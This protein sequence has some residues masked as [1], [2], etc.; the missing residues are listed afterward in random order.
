[1]KLLLDTH[2][3][4]WAAGQSPQLSKTARDL[5]ENRQNELFFSAASIWEI[6][7]KNG[8]GRADFQVDVSVLR[9]SLLDNEYGE[10]TINSEHAV[11]VKNLPPIHKDP[12]DRMLIAQ[13]SVEGI[14]LLTSD[15]TVAQYVGSIRKV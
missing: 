11:Y 5:I 15:A 7:I 14:T 10:L 8:L 1:M 13:S 9:R 3:L 6:T 4:L 12:F 2:L